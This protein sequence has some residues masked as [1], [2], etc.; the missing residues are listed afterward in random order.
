MVLSAIR[1]GA[2]RRRD[3]VRGRRGNP[4]AGQHDSL[5]IGWPRRCGMLLPVLVASASTAVFAVLVLAA[6]IA[7]YAL[8]WPSRSYLLVI[9]AK[10][11]L[12]WLVI[13][14]LTSVI[15]NA[16]IVRLVSISAWLVAALSIIGQLEP[17]IDALELGLGGARRIAADA[18]G[19]DQARRCC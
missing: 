18:A 19:A 16:F 2:G 6:R 17:A 11:A 12:A 3:S 14:L 13:R 1:P 8:T 15:R 9:A 4:L 7:M 10:L 5:A